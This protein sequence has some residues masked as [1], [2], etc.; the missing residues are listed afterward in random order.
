MECEACSFKIRFA[1]I[2]QVLS[3]VAFNMADTDLT[4]T[5]LRYTDRHLGLPLLSHLS[6]LEL[7]KQEGV[8]KAMYELAKGTSMVDFALQLHEQAYSGQAPPQDMDKKR[9]EIV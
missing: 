2:T 9:Q 5:I 3:D 1:A 6:N 8:N 4:S 7:F